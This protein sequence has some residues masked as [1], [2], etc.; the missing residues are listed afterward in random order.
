MTDSTHSFLFIFSKGPHSNLD[1]KEGVDFSLAAAAFGQQV[2]VLFIEDSIFQLVEDQNPRLISSKNHSSTLEALSLYGVE[3]I[4]ISQH[5]LEK[6][7]IST[8]QLMPIGKTVDANTIKS[9]I[10]KHDFVFNY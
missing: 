9:I 2:S 8:Q 7:D 10:T 5:D 1:A 3:E 4:F 6:R